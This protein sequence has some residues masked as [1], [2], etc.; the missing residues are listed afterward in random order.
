MQTFTATQYLKID[1]ASSF[2][3][4]K[5]PWRDRLTWFDMN[6]AKLPSLVQQAKEPA[7]FYAG[8]MAWNAAKKGDPIGYMISL[9]ATSSGL[10]ILAALTGDRLAAKLCNVVDTGKREDAYTNIYQA[11]LKKIDDTMKIKAEDVKQAIMTAFYNSTAVPKQVF[12]EGA[13]LDIF[14][15]TVIEKAP[16]P[17]ELNEAMLKIWNPSAS[18]HSWVLPDNF[19]VH[20]KVMDTDKEIVHFQNEPFDVFTKVNRPMREGRSLGA[21]TVHSIDGMIV[22][23]L[24]RRCDYDPAKIE[25]IKKHTEGSTILRKGTKTKDDEMVV[26]LW[27][28]FEKSGFLSAR[29]LDHLN[30]G[31]MGH[32]RSHDIRELILSLPAK[33]F[34]IVSIHD[35]FRVHPNYGNDLR[36]QYNIQLMMIAKSNLLSY[37]VAQLLGKKI[38]I[39]K[40][41]R[42]LWKDIINADYALS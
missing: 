15:Q 16:G 36:K 19:H 20:V 39:N 40:L 41:D 9:D 13:L 23:E 4:S 31:N 14:Y 22:K 42:N 26:T 7:L 27:D 8:M 17:W 1:I 18:C 6:E 28:H 34:K 37:I 5:L 33:P 38:Q 35:C 29:I 32:C 25:D 21:N 2:G 30:P 11:M 3:L 12:G 10:Q 24:T